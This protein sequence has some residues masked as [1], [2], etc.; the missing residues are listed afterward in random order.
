MVGDS[1]HID[2][3]H[4]AMQIRKRPSVL[5]LPG[6]KAPNKASST[7]CFASRQPSSGLVAGPLCTVEMYQA[8]DRIANQMT[9]DCQSDSKN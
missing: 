7:T 4:S 6:A 3:Y 9:G 8:E 5:V 2:P 1:L